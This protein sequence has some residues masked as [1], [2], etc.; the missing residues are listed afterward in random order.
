MQLL[1]T[2]SEEFAITK[3]LN[4]I[5]GTV[6]KLSSGPDIRVPNIGWRKITPAR[7]NILADIF[8]ENTMMYF[9]HSYAFFLDEIE[10]V[11]A[12][13]DVNGSRITAIVRR[14]NIIGCQFHPEKSG[15]SGLKLIRW[16]LDL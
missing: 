3:G 7:K 2:Q 13:V 1:A 8:S 16:F 14:G 5:P 12:T 10:D 4:L 15:K 9:V 6:K 11:V